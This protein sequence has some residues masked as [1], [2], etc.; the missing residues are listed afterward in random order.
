MRIGNYLPS[1]FSIEN[2]LKHED[3]LSRLL[4]NFALEFVVRK[5]QESNLGLDMSGTHLVMD[6][7]NLLGDNIRTTERNANVLLSV[8]KGVGLAVNTGETKYMKCHRGM[9][10]NKHITVGMKK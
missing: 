9:I 8:C 1:S 10:A 5:V 7:V 6:D 3:G 4:F 2:D